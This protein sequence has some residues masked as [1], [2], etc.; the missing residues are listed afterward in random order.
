MLILT[1]DTTSGVIDHDRA[2]RVHRIDRSV[3]NSQGFRNNLA[4][5]G[6]VWAA[7]ARVLHTGRCCSFQH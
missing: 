6:E 3:T 4:K 7:Y 1:P 5:N 2:E